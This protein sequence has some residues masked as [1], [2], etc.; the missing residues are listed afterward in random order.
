MALGESSNKKH[1]EANP[2]PKV[3]IGMPVYNGD[4]FIC[5]ALDSLLAQTFTDFELIIS[6]NGSTDDTEKICRKYA[7]RDSRIKYVRQ[8]ENRGGMWNFQ[9]VLSEASAKYFMWAAHDDEWDPLWLETLLGNFEH[10]VVLSFGNIVSIDHEGII[11]RK[12][13]CQSY[14]KRRFLRLIQFFIREEYNGKANM[15]YGLFLSETLRKKELKLYF[16]CTFGQDNHFLFDVLHDGQ[17][18]VDC[19]VLL[20]KRI[21]VSNR[22]MLNPRQRVLRIVNALFLL[23]HVRYYLTYGAI[24]GGEFMKLIILL[25]FPVKYIKSV[26]CAWLRAFVNWRLNF[27]G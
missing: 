20:R 1:P 22:G 12:C 17:V 26:S 18:I 11:L 14:S 7:E 8:L 21:V 27:R 3:S 13:K 16:G 6:D 10:G 23:D 24:G 19:R 2:M 9:F 4:Q 5:K 25:C 15:I